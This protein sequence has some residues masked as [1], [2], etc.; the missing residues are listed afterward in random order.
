[1]RSL[2]NREREKAASSNSKNGGGHNSNDRNGN[3]AEDSYANGN[4][5]S[6]EDDIR[7]STY[8]YDRSGASSTFLRL[9]F[10]TNMGVCLSAL[11]LSYVLLYA[12][13]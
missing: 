8:Y 7:E 10:R 12:T 4:E 9:S 3:Y 11:L 1:M 2:L 6:D 13:Y 5:E